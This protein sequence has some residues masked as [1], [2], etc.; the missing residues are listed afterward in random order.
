VAVNPAGDTALVA[1]R[2]HNVHVVRIGR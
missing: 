1:D 2:D